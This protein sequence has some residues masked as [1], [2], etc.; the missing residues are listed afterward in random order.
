MGGQWSSLVFFLR[1]EEKQHVCITVQ[2]T[3]KIL[4]GAEES[5]EL[6]EQCP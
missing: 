1:W 5:G 3:Q 6:P 4:E 2:I